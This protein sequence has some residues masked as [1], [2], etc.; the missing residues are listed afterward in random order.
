MNGPEL[1][2]QMH[3]SILDQIGET[4]SCLRVVA[5]RRSSESPRFFK[6]LFASPEHLCSAASV[7]PLQNLLGGADSRAYG[8]SER[9]VHPA[10]DG[11]YRRKSRTV[12]RRYR[13]IESW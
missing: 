4:S 10:F 11:L 2:S 7:G 1:A 9:R 3:R 5:S 13:N 8:C 12:E 6:I